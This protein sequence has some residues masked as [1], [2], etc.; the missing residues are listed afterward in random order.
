MELV[1]IKMESDQD[2]FHLKNS[3]HI[4]LFYTLLT[5]HWSSLVTVTATIEPRELEWEGITRDSPVPG[6]RGHFGV[7]PIFQIISLRHYRDKLLDFTMAESDPRIT[8]EQ[9]PTR[10]DDEDMSITVHHDISD[11]SNSIPVDFFWIHPKNV[12]SFVSLL[13]FYY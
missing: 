2:D 5:S 11:C 8:F 3:D 10:T 6:Y 13:V 7:I 4:D 12:L 9:T 1:K